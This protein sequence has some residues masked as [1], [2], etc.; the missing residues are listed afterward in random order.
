MTRVLH[1]AKS[2]NIESVDIEDDK[3]L[4]V[5]TQKHDSIIH[6]YTKCSVCGLYTKQ[7]FFSGKSEGRIVSYV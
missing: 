5:V 3:C 1:T 7:K 6:F 4:D 2:S